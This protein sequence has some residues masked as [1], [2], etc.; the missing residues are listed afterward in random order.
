MFNFFSRFWN[1]LS[2]SFITKP[3]TSPLGLVVTIKPSEVIKPTRSNRWILY[4][5][6]IDPFLI[7]DVQIDPIIPNPVDDPKKVLT[8]MTIACTI[9]YIWI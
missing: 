4:L 7:R 3:L 5:D 9:H 8:T 2:E 6:K 1:W